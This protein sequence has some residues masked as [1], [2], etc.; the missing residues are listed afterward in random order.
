M[1]LDSTF[2]WIF[3]CVVTF[4][5]LVRIILEQTSR[6]QEK[7]VFQFWQRVGLPMGTEQIHDSLRSRLHRSSMAALVGGIAGALVATSLLV[8]Q[9]A[10]VVSFTFSWLVALPA[11][12]IGL[13]LSDVV[14]TLRD[15]LFGSPSNLPRMARA[16]AVTLGDY[17]SPWR[18]RTAPLLL[19]IALFLAAGGLVLGQSGV[20]NMGSFLKGMSLPFLLVAIIV[21]GICAVAAKKVLEKSQPVADALE[22]AWD[23]AVRADTIRKLAQLA[24]L[25]A[26]LASSAIVIAI[27]EGLQDGREPMLLV[28]MGQP[29][30]M[31]GYSVVVMMFSYGNSYSYFRHR[32]WP[33]FTPYG[34]ASKQGA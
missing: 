23:D 26:W 33:D 11:I 3:I 12:F 34:L 27:L 28:A 13:T 21:C 14:Q 25:T 9:E 6:L 1:A 29:L 17:I 8:F 31:V 19:L 32:L 20:I 22:L 4:L 24:V 5:V 15:T 30:A 7:R 10:S 2:N 18:L 16:H